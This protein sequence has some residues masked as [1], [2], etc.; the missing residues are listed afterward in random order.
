MFFMTDRQDPDVKTDRQVGVKQEKPFELQT[1]KC[2]PIYSIQIE[3]SSKYTHVFL[4]FP[5]INLLFHH[6]PPAVEDVPDSV[7]HADLPEAGAYPPLIP[8]QGDV[9]VFSDLRLYLL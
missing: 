4:M 3:L 9:F 1:L 5:G 6:L 8:G 7:P 2:H